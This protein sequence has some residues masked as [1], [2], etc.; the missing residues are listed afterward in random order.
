[1]I[2]IDCK[3]ILDA[4]QLHEKLK[5]QLQFPDYYGYTLDALF[6]C[7]TSIRVDTTICLE[8]FVQLGDWK[9]RFLNTFSNVCQ[10][11]PHMHIIL[12]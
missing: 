4:R 11:N 2:L 9:S 3:G 6:D 1:M 10:E 5:T 8:G 12:A 7:L